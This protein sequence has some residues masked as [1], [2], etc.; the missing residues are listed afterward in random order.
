MGGTATNPA[1]SAAILITVP[2]AWQATEKQLPAKTMMAGA[3]SLPEPTWCRG[4]FLARVGFRSA[5]SFERAVNGG[6]CGSSGCLAPGGRLVR[7]L[8]PVLPVPRAG[9]FRDC[10]SSAADRERFGTRWVLG[11]SRTGIMLVEFQGVR[12]HPRAAPCEATARAVVSR[13]RDLPQD[14]GSTRTDVPDSCRVH[15]S[16]SHIRGLR[17]ASK[18]LISKRSHI[19]NFDPQS[20]NGR[21]LAVGLSGFAGSGGG[22]GGA[23]TAMTRSHG[24]RAPAQE[25]RPGARAW[26]RRPGREQADR[27]RAI[28]SGSGRRRM[29]T[30][31]QTGRAVLST[32]NPAGQRLAGLWCWLGRLLLLA[33]ELADDDRDRGADRR[34]RDHAL[35]DRDDDELEGVQ[36]LLLLDHRGGGGRCLAGR[37]GRRPVGLGGGGL[38]GRGSVV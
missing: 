5:G 17:H 35:Q 2:P 7:R 26:G 30:Y 34:D 16:T 12:G 31:F 19:A 22:L 18:L 24:P 1:N 6:D 9:W 3:G 20:L 4:W 28:A 23:V 38:R 29:P 14:R 36:R 33:G 10:G 21:V 15:S 32:H 37:V 13:L 27:R 25:R 8:C 11:V